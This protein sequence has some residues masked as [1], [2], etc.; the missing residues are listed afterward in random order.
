MYTCYNMVKSF[1]QEDSQ[2]VKAEF[3]QV[4]N[5]DRNPL[6]DFFDVKNQLGI[7]TSEW[8]TCQKSKEM[9][10]VLLNNCLTG[11]NWL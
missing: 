11:K 10:L 5:F 8:L 3:F 1:L 7:G 2:I 4:D 6:R 9:T